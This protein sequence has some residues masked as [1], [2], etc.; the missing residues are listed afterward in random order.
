MYVKS[1]KCV[2]NSGVRVDTVCGKGNKRSGT[3]QENDEATGGGGK[4][5]VAAK[6]GV[7][8]CAITVEETHECR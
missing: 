4:M 5:F 6:E 8:Q 7:K 3:V 2:V 1:K